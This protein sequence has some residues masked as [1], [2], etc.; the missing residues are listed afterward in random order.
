M[1]A[2]QV[3]TKPG[4]RRPRPSLSGTSTTVYIVLALVILVIAFAVLGPEGRFLSL[5]NLQAIGRNSAELMLLAVGLTFVLGAGHIDLSV[6]ANLVLSS[7]VSATVILRLAGSDAEVAAGSYPNAGVAIAV[8]VLA[9]LVTGTAVGVVNGLLVT[10]LRVNSFVVTLGTMGIAT[11]SAQVITNGS[12]VPNL[13][14]TLQSGIG[15][16]TLAAVP[17]PLVVS[18]VAGAI[19][20][21]LMTQ[22]AFGRHGLAIGSASSAARRAGVNVGGTTVA[23]FALSGLLAGAAGVLDLTRFGTTALSGHE[24]DV[25]QALSAV[26]IGGTSLFGGRASV[27]GSVVATFIPTVLL[28]GFVMVGVAPF[29]QGIAIG[30]VLILAVWIDGLRRGQLVP[31]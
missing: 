2:T 16:R 29:Y 31:R 28:A 21:A 26:I 4:S 3:P 12:N 5:T 23:V 27:A 30:V 24:T 11:G 15:L 17:V 10:R 19:G 7:V 18:L 14:L 1:T 6:G 25:L 20:V 9:A 13:P 8:G 22:T